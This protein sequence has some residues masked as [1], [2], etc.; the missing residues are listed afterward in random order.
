MVKFLFN[1]PTEQLDDLRRFSQ[2]TGS[3]VAE[4][5]RQGINLL[6]QS[7]VPCGVIVSGAIASGFIVL[8]RGK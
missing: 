5:I 1:L 8:V 6:L 2:D 4:C 7:Q 3:P